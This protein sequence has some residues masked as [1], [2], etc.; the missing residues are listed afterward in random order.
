MKIG[1][2]ASPAMAAWAMQLAQAA[3][4]VAAHQSSPTDRPVEPTQA[5]SDDAGIRQ[6]SRHSFDIRV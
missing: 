4:R 1:Y 3:T 6:P 5:I 2:S